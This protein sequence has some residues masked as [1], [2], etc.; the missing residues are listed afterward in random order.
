MGDRQRYGWDFEASCLHGKNDISAQSSSLC[1]MNFVS[2]LNETL[3]L[4]YLLSGGFCFFLTETVSE[5]NRGK[6]GATRKVRT[7]LFKR[8]NLSRTLMDFG[9]QLL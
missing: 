1:I 3:W 5:N 8:E 7:Q 6:K 9:T 4:L 2:R